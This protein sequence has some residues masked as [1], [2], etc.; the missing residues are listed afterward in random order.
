MVS[1]I[2][3]FNQR[4]GNRKGKKNTTTSTEVVNFVD[5]F[6]ESEQYKK[7]QEMGIDLTGFSVDS[8]ESLKKALIEVN[9]LITEKETKTDETNTPPS[10]ENKNDQKED[11]PAKD[12]DTLEI[13]EAGVDTNENL[14]VNG[15]GAENDQQHDDTPS[16]SDWINSKREFYSKFAQENNVTFKNDAEKDTSEKAFTF[17]FEKR[18]FLHHHHQQNYLAYW[19][20]VIFRS[21]I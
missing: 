21:R 18:T 3:K 4:Y 19:A 14:E 17:S 10:A 9:K 12:G 5:Q 8:E 13:D 1:Q 2:D 7:A 11:A 6:K 20:Q 15:T 16:N